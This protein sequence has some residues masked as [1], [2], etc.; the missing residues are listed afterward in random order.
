M[1]YIQPTEE[2]LKGILG[3]QNG[4]IL[5]SDIRKTPT[6]NNPW[7]RDNKYFSQTKKENP[8]A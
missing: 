8:D 3:P 2:A 4:H 7:P 6:L 1:D 5:R